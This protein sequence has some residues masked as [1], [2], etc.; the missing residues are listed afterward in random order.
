MAVSVDV[1]VAEIPAGIPARLAD[2]VGIWTGQADVTGDATGTFVALAWDVDATS[3]RRFVYVIDTMS[4]TATTASDVGNCRVTVRNRMAL[5]NVNLDATREAVVDF[6]VAD[7]DRQVADFHLLKDFM[8]SFPI[9]WQRDFGGVQIVRTV[10]QNNI[11]TVV[12]TFRIGGRFWDAR[13]LGSRDFQALW[14]P[15]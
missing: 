3:T 4:V 5:A 6:A 2:P 1:E 7:G 12:Y 8:R 10:I 15:G 11:D 9:F 14:R 13:I